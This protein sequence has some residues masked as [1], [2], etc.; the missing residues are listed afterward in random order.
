ML[1]VDPY[2]GLGDV[3]VIAAANQSAAS[4]CLFPNDDGTTWSQ[5]VIASTAFSRTEDGSW[6]LSSVLL[7]VAAPVG[8]DGRFETRLLGG[9]MGHAWLIEGEAAVLDD[10]VES[11]LVDEGVLFFSPSSGG[12]AWPLLFQ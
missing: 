8:A 9:D 1:R 12:S 10:L 2:E 3:A 7:A 5:A 6:E 11:C 4:G